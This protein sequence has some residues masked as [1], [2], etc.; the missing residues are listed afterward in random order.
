MALHALSLKGMLVP[1]CHRPTVCSNSISEI[2]TPIF[3]LLLKWPVAH[4]TLLVSEVFYLPLLQKISHRS[5]SAGIL[6]RK[7][8][9]SQVVCDERRHCF[10]MELQLLL[11][12]ALAVPSVLCVEGKHRA[13]KYSLWYFI[14]Q[15]WVVYID[16][17][18]FCFFLTH[19]R[20]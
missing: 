7:V 1:L 5:R 11:I 12:L 9:Y 15:I 19:C 18:Y 17:C 3:F 6:W 16:S 2:C 20:G 14:N 13:N 8:K 10:S 4:I